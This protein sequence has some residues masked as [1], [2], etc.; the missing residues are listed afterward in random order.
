MANR[1]LETWRKNPDW[2]MVILTAATVI[3]SAVFFYFQLKD[4]HSQLQD[5]HSQLQVAQ[6][7]FEASQKTARLEQ[8]AWVEATLV[9]EKLVHE[10]ID[11]RP[12]AVLS[13]SIRQT[14]IGKVPAWN[15]NSEFIFEIVEA[16]KSP[17]P[18]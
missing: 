1:V 2:W 12:N 8:R 3:L 4:T 14:N 6:K 17:A 11:I 18:A 15:V 10:K 13:V 5:T 7:E 16:T 9:K